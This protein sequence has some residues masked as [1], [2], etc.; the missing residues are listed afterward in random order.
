MDPSWFTG[1]PPSRPAGAT[2][3]RLGWSKLGP[4]KGSGRSIWD[5]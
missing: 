1:A 4:T 5:R 2:A 3:G